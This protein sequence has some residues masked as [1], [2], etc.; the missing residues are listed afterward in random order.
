MRSLILV[1][2]SLAIFGHPA[3]ASDPPRKIKPALVWHGND[4]GQARGSFACCR[5]RAEWQATWE[6]HQKEGGDAGRPAADVDFDSF[7]VVA[8]FHGDG[9]DNFGIDVDE[10][11]DD[12]GCLR[13]RYRVLYY[14]TAFNFSESEAERLKRATRS[15]AVAVLPRS[16]KALVFE[17]A[18]HRPDDKTHIW[19][20]RG[21]VAAVE[22]K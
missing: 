17:E 12:A 11:V 15:F 10:V 16:G 5:T 18:K 3:P 8:I 2:L 4:S 20:E 13:I 1:G 21:R 22:R 6:A 9:S 7:M 14:Q 19:K